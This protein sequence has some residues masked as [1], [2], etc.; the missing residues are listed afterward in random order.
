MAAPKKGLGSKGLGIEA[1][2]NTQ[3]DELNSSDKNKEGVFEVD[4]NKIEPNRKQPRKYFEES[5]LEELAESIK[6]YGL[7]QPIV[8]RSIDDGQYEIIAGERRWRSSKIAGIKKVPVIVKD[9]DSEVSFEVALVENLQRENLNPIEEAE[10]YQKLYEEFNLSQEKIAEK[11][12]KSRSFISNS[13]RLLNL[14]ERVKGFVKENKLS[15]GHA[16]ALL[17]IEDK[18]IQFDLAEKIIENQLSVRET[19][20]LIKKIING[21]EKN[22]IKEQQ[23][24]KKQWNMFESELRMCLGTKVKISNK[25]NKG[26]IEIE[27]YSND[28]LDRIVNIIKRTI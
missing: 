26:K 5:A 6:Q 22:E 4:I 17:A 11:V 16:R 18:D 7:I 10:S 23:E 1:L 25:K 12:G 19:E 14:D 21:T 9:Y 28:D 13:M 3:L 15:N 20:G 24:D 8:V 27:Y 2:I